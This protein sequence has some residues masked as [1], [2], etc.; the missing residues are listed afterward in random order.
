MILNNPNKDGHVSRGKPNPEASERMKKNNPR[1]SAKDVWSKAVYQYSLEGNFIKKWDSITLA[2]KELGLKT[3][4]LT[5]NKSAGFMWRL[6]Y[7]G[8]KIEPYFTKTKAKQVSI[9]DKDFNIIKT[10]D[11]LKECGAYLNINK[12]LV[13]ARI[14]KQIYNEYYFAFGNEKTI[15][16]TRVKKRNKRLVPLLNNRE[17]FKRVDK[18]LSEDTGTYYLYRHIREDINVPFYIGIGKKR[19]YEYSHFCKSELYHRANDKN[20]RNSYWKNVVK[21]LNGLFTVEILMESNDYL[22][23]KQ[24]EIEF[25][26]LYKKTS[27]G[28]TLT[29]LTLGGEGTVGFRSLPNLGYFILATNKQTGEKTE[30]RSIKECGKSLKINRYNVSKIIKG[31][32]SSSVWNLEKIILK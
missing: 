7:L 21:K 18:N 4:L 23:I 13:S 15:T 16:I 19:E 31:T 30:F 28:G 25:I 9:Y 20:R 32:K 24:K 17:L 5:K 11:S 29:N 12:S 6:E 3:K 22:F 2:T 14:K 8:E 10:F 26:D 1:H 27:E